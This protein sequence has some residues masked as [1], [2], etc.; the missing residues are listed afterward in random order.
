MIAF[1]IPLAVLGWSFDADK[2]THL[3]FVSLERHGVAYSDALIRLLTAT[4]SNK[5]D[6][7]TEQAWKTMQ[8]I[9]G[10][11]GSVLD[12]AAPFQRLTQAAG[13]GSS[14]IDAN[15]Q[16]ALLDHVVDTSNLALD[17]DISSYYLMDASVIAAPRLA[18]G[19][20]KLRAKLIKVRDQGVD[21]PLTLVAL[22]RESDTVVRL[23]DQLG[24]STDKATKE[25]VA[26]QKSVPVAEAQSAL[27]A[28]T[29]LSGGVVQ[30]K[31]LLVDSQEIARVADRALQA[32][33]VYMTHALPILD[34]LLKERQQQLTLRRL[35]VNTLTL[36]C[37]AL[38]LYLLLCFYFVTRGGMEEV[39]QHLVAMTEGDLTTHPQPW[40][41]DEAASL[42]LSLSD[43]QGALR[44]VVR[45][46]RDA[47][48]AIVHSSSEIASGS[49]D[50]S[51][52]TE[53]T[54]SSLEQAAS[55]MDQIASTVTQTS[56]QAGQTALLA[57]GNADVAIQGGHVIAQV[58]DTMHGIHESSS[59][60][61]DIIS[62]ID[63]IAFQTNILALNAAVEAA[64]A[65]EQGRGFAVVAS[66]VRALA[67][68]SASAAHE[69]KALINDSVE[70]VSS[71][72]KVVQSAG[73]TMADIVGNAQRMNGLLSEIATAAREQSTGVS[74]VGHSIQE[75]DRSTQGNAALVEE[76]A[77]A[78]ASLK[79]QAVSLARA[80]SA[81]R[82]PE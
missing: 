13:A 30:G 44:A 3:A 67:K 1:L 32:V 79:E 61:A 75:L 37:L 77:A 14:A 40:G 16:M 63:G 2:R 39:R 78:A 43:M 71:G 80:V 21:S 76:T 53:R 11:H 82:L 35:L 17:P 34:S 25:Q 31:P 15:A 69:I 5:D 6:A 65:G 10:Q 47:S 66:E 56:D 73:Q 9:H 36:V 70:K 60:I 55:A 7:A 4:L 51:N 28:L 33:D 48:D 52:R 45:E 18:H 20:A 50:L 38:A 46:V 54:A 26:L 22:Q 62:V 64:R 29:E 12:A 58:V 68:R 49:T 59:K 23:A 41:Q 81:F 72:T 24:V 19:V 42:M 27:F 8:V 74:Q 57:S